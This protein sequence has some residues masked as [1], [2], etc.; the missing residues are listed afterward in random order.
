MVNGSKKNVTFEPYRKRFLG[1]QTKKNQW[2]QEIPNGP[3]NTTVMYKMSPTHHN[4][5]LVLQFGPCHTYTKSNQQEY[6]YTSV[7]N[8]HITVFPSMGGAKG[9]IMEATKKSYR[10]R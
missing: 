1:K 5:G 3:T 7:N 2:L 8:T 9:I 4:A 6:Q 10:F